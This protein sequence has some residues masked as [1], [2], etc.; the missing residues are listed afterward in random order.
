MNMKRCV[1]C[2][3]GPY[4]VGKTSLLDRI[5]GEAFSDNTRPTIGGTLAVTTIDGTT[6]VLKDTAGEERYASIIPIMLRGSDVFVLCVECMAKRQEAL[7]CIDKYMEIIKDSSDN[8]III[9]ALTKC[10]LC[11]EEPEWV[12][13]ASKRAMS[14]LETSAKENYNI[15]ALRC[16][17]RGMYELS[18]KRNIIHENGDNILFEKKNKKSCC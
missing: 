10:D 4:G 8:P 2:F 9:I 14:I 15:D 6:Y 5:A 17:I 7:E 12:R 13:E 3:L 18:S 1:V 16:S 11:K